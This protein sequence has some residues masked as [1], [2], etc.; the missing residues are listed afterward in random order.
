MEQANHP[1]EEKQLDGSINDYDFNFQN[2][3]HKK[4][5]KPDQARSNKANRNSMNF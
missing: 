4:D 3:V 5:E 1:D 2:L